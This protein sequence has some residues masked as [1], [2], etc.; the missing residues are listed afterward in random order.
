MTRFSKMSSLVLILGLT[1]LAGSVFAV[2]EE[3]IVLSVGGEVDHPGQWTMPELQA[4]SADAVVVTDEHEKTAE[5]RCVTFQQL[6]ERAGAV[7]GKAIKG[8][9]L[10]DYLVVTAADNYRVLF[11][12]PEIDALFAN[13]KVFLCHTKNGHPL[14]DAEGPLRVLV[15]DEQRHARWVRHV[16]E[17]AIRHLQR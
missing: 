2:D 3:R 8:E 14:P 10:T 13:R 11:A 7:N 4:L 12:L 16:T 15:P 9:R 6:L 5:Y 1:L 17:I